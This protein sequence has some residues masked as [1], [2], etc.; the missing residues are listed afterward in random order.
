MK[1]ITG[2]LT[3]EINNKFLIKLID[4]FEKQTNTP[5]GWI[6]YRKIYLYSLTQIII[7]LSIPLGNLF[8]NN[9]NND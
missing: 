5:T 1:H 4:K 2:R 7:N 9:I 6:V 8:E 3:S